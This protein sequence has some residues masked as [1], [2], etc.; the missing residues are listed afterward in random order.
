M[1]LIDCYDLSKA[2]RGVRAVD[3]LNL[4]VPRG[5]IYGLVGPN[6]A[7]KTTA[8]KML[9]NMAPPDSGRAEIMSCDSRWLGPAQFARLGYVS[10]NQELPRWMTVE[11]FMAYLK[12]FYPA[13]DDARAAELLRNFDL[14]GDRQLRHLSRGMWMKAS[15][16]SSLAYRPDLLVLDEP[17]SGLDPLV[18]EELIQGLLDSAEETTI[19]C[20]SHDLSEIETL[21]SHIGFMDGGVL[22][23]SE[24]MAVLQSRFRE[25]EITVA[26]PPELPRNGRWPARWI[27]PEASP[28]LVR[29][30]D[31]GYDAGRT[32]ADVRAL[33]E[34][35]TDVMANPMPLKSIF[36]AMARVSRGNA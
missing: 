15:L 11:Y 6:G 24:E 2:Y 35:V 34:G 31:T 26:I 28:S 25:V 9:L 22:R 4:K 18:R 19:L 10:E 20:S 14:P 21:A 3:R 16:A 36:L 5:A 33:F 1:N 12:P 30:V 29:F 17:F 7:G 13:W 27:R 23:L 8:I 32:E